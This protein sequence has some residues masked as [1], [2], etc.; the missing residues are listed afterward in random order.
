MRRPPLLVQLLFIGA[1][2]LFFVMLVLIIGYAI[3]VSKK[4][5]A[6]QMWVSSVSIVWY[7]AVTISIIGAMRL[8]WPPSVRFITS[9]LAFS[10]FGIVRLVGYQSIAC[11]R[12]ISFLVMVGCGRCVP[13]ERS[14]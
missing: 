3:L 6:T 12:K 7:H 5:G 14:M 13:R 10:F 11:S 4:Q 8:T 2:A 9:S 1:V